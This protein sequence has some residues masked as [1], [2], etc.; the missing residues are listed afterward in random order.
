VA[1]AKTG[2]V[3]IYENPVLFISLIYGF[4]NNPILKYTI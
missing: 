1:M 2:H 3:S 4:M